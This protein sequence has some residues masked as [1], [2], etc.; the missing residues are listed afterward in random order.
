MSERDDE[1]RRGGGAEGASVLPPCGVYRTTMR[2]GEVPAGRFVFFH[3][4][5]D[6]SPGIY[7]PASWRQNRAVFHERGVP[8]P[9]DWWAATLDPIA[10]E[11]FYRVRESF[12]C[13]EKRC[14]V[15][16]VDQLVQL[17]Y[18]GEANPLLFV[19]E[20]IDLVLIIPDQGTRIDRA[21]VAKLS[22]L[23]TPTSS[24]APGLQ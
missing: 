13:C 23:K 17:G 20:V 15:Y 7:L 12:A 24:T 9:G 6:P 2:L 11:G 10:P 22:A 14:A 4:H 5:G 18:D 19:P 3:N 21:R 8:I 16:E 1:E